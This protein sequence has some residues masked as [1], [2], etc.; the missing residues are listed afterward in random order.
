MK[1]TSKF[2]LLLLSVLTIL[3]L[4]GIPTSMGS[5]I[6]V[7]GFSSLSVIANTTPS[8]QSAKES[9]SSN[10]LASIKIENVFDLP[11]VQQPSS[12]PGYVSTRNN[13]LTQFG[14]ASSYGSIGILAHNYLAGKYFSSLSSGQVITLT[15]ADG[16]TKNYTISSIKQ[17]QALTPDSQY[18]KFVD[19]NDSSK[20]LSS[21][22]LFMDTFGLSNA[23]VL[24]TCITKNGNSSWGRLFVIAY[25]S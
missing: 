13:T 11:V 5:T 7:T 17:Y 22:D 9:A 4:A 16:T 6:P 14:L 3:S 19:L 8:I 12:N 10:Q 23:L 21:S 18:S 24:Q 1:T 25:A 2:F 15:F 20:T